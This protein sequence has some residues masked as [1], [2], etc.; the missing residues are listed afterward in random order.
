L[1]SSLWHRLLWS[2]LPHFMLRQYSIFAQV[3]I[4]LSRSAV[5]WPRK[6]GS[7]LDILLSITGGGSGFATAGYTG[8]PPSSCPWSSVNTTSHQQFYSSY[9]ITAPGFRSAPTG[10]SDHKS[11]WSLKPSPQVVDT[12]VAQSSECLLDRQMDASRSSEVERQSG[13]TS[14]PATLPYNQEF[15][16]GNLFY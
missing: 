13:S 5:W 4:E 9:R 7:M 11:Q 14:N 2:L 16:V 3:F 1:A 12:A 6:A 15:S 8:Q 10:T